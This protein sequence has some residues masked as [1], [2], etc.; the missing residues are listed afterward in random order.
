LPGRGR[1]INQI[2]L[3]LSGWLALAWARPAYKPNSAGA[4]WLAGWL[5]PGR[6]RPINQILLELS[7][8]LLIPRRLKMSK[9]RYASDAF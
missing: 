4:F 8:W 3:E 5:L 9:S 6:G 7:G 2:L 1:P